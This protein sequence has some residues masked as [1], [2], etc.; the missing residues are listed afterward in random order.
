M[1]CCAS[2]AAR[3]SSCASCTGRCGPRPPPCDALPRP[4]RRRPPRS[5]GRP[6]AGRSSATA[7][8]SAP[9]PPQEALFA[10]ANGYM[11]VRGADRRGQPGIGPGG[12]RGGPL[13]RR[14]GGHRRPGRDRRLDAHPARD[15]RPRV[16]SLG[17]DRGHPPAQA[18]P[19]HDGARAHARVRRSRRAPAAARVAA[20]AQPGAAAPGRDPA[21]ARAR[22]R[23]RPRGCARTP[24]CTPARSTRPL[25]HVEVVAAGR[26]DGVDL[27]HTRTAGRPRRRRRRDGARRCGSAATTS[28]TEWDAPTDGCGPVG[29]GRAA[30]RAMSS[31]STGSSRSTPSASGRC[32]PWTP[33]ARRARPP[34]SGWDARAGRAQRRVARGLGPDRRRGRRAPPTASRSAIRFAVAQLIAIAPTADGR[35]SIAAKG[36]T[37]DGYKGHVFWDTDVFLMPFYAAALPEVA[38][39]APRVP[40]DHAAR[41]DA[42]RRGRRPGRRVVRVGVGGVGRGRD[43]RLRHRAR[44]GA[45]CGC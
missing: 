27:L 4:R 15:R 16:P 37:G 29:R 39:P 41:G 17:V 23:A 31:R 9:K 8:T 36:L 44:A 10:L 5:S 1:G 43:A 21:A 33:S 24:A 40:P 14:R 22:G 20:A 6:T 30:R 3:P 45:G 12:V 32:R 2:A 25:P 38:R 19:A 7:T 34:P 35:C 26:A 42:Q 13:R 28:Q 11:G 18:R